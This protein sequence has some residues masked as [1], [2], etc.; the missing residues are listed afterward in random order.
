MFSWMYCWVCFPINSCGLSL[1][2][3]QNCQDHEIHLEF[4][5]LCSIQGDEFFQNYSSQT[6]RISSSSF[7]L[8][9]SSLVLPGSS[10]ARFIHSTAAEVFPRSL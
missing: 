7:S 6:E 8:S 5:C 4:Y 10:E 9:A 2:C 3:T 1:K